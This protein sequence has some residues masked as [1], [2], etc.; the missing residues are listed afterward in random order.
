MSEQKII[1]FLQKNGPSTPA[2]V[3]RVLGV[4]LLF[5]SA[6]LGEASSKGHVKI[7]KMK[8]GS[9]P[10]YYLESTREKLANFSDRLNPKDRQAFELL[11]S[12]L[13]LRDRNQS[14]IVRVSLR[15]IK[16]FAIPL[17]IVRNG[18]NETFWKW[19]MLTDHDATKKIKEIFEQAD[20]INNSNTNNNKIASVN[21]NI[22]SKS[23]KKTQ[24]LVDEEEEKLQKTVQTAKTKA[25]ENEVQNIKSV[26]VREKEIKQKEHILEKDA[27]TTLSANSIKNVEPI[28]DN[29]VIESKSDKKREEYIEE[30]KELQKTV[31]TAKTEV[32]INIDKNSNLKISESSLN[33]DFSVQCTSPFGVKVYN[34]FKEKK[35]VILNY[36]LDNKKT[37]FSFI[38]DVPNAIASTKYY[39]KAVDK[40]TLNEGDLA[41]VLLEGN[42]KN[43]PTIL[44]TTGKTSKKIEE[45]LNN[46]F[47]DLTII[48]INHF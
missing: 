19:Y 36:E 25:I 39:L 17:N 3:G 10:L 14:P 38:I 40:K 46:L 48:K 33:E 41:L 30:E 35:F 2:Q 31:Q 12:K 43:L 9:S 11:K 20:G 29:N 47:K 1:E 8:T 16:D 24:G 5:A 34:Y 15:A 23:D 27:Q 26:P 4:Q 44:L 28:K 18:E 32:K 22:E 13:V 42:Y 6:M 21:D 7:S 37:K 45:K